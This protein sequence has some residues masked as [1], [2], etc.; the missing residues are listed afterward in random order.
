MAILFIKYTNSN[1]IPEVHRDGFLFHHPINNARA[2]FH[3]V[4][5][6]GF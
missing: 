6:A 1:A 5:P 3:K 2:I 4:A